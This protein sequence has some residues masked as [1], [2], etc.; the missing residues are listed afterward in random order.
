MERIFFQDLVILWVISNSASS[1]T[2]RMTIAAANQW[3][4]SNGVTENYSLPLSSGRRGWAR[5]V[6]LLLRLGLLRHIDPR[7]GYIE[8]DGCSEVFGRIGMRWR[9]WPLSMPILDDEIQYDKA[10]FAPNLRGDL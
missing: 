5:S 2:H 3:M 1:M 8:T 7:G 10:V 9:E 4:R 6:R